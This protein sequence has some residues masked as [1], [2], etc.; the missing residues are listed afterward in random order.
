M[1]MLVAALVF[2]PLLALAIAFLL[3]SI[4]RTWPMRDKDMLARAISGRPGAAAVPPWW[5]TFLVGAFFLT[6]GVV[7]LALADHDSGG[8]WLSALGVAL[9]VLFLVRG[10]MG[11][12]PRWRRVFPAEPF[13]TLDRKTYSPLALLIGVGFAILVIMRLL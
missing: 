10:G 7:G 2:V 8:A 4:G 13:A 5:I 12:T 3:W 1:S 9:S 6:A 11:F